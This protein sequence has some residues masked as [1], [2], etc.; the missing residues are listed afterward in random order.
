LRSDGSTRVILCGKCK[1]SVKKRLSEREPLKERTA[2]LFLKSDASD[3]RQAVSE[4]AY[5]HCVGDTAVGSEDVRP[6]ALGA[7]LEG[8]ESE[9]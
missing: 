8:Y 9:E 7:V 2:L 6:E 5:D 1:T 3:I 4:F